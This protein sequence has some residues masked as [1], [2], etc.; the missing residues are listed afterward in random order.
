MKNPPLMSNWKH[1]LPDCEEAIK[2]YD[3]LMEDLHKISASVD[4][5]NEE[6]PHKSQIFNP[7]FL[8]TSVSI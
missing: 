3:N 6:R 5:R 7:K 2:L 1:L 8:E 4:A